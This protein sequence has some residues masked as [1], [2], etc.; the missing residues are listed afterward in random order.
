[1]THPNG[2]A[3]I[4]VLVADDHP[5]MREGLA[6]AI[7]SQ[8]DMCVAGEA[9][10]GAEALA[11]HAEARPD[12]TLMDISLPDMCGVSAMLEIRRAC[13]TARIIMLTT[14]R[15]DAQIRRAVQGGAAGFLLKSSVRSD[16]L[17]AIRAVHAGQ[18]RI[19]AEIALEL[20]QHLNHGSLSEREAQVLQCAA[21]GNSNKRI[22]VVLA[23]SEET[24]KAHMR[25]ILSK[26]DANDRT[27]AVAI[28]IRRGI[29]SL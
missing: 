6:Q 5:M 27:H 14:F 1:M 23:I 19:P 13:P 24:V 28:A 4:R 20:A 10:T 7:A 12:V 11:A 29:I 2:V 21:C 16:L 9:A 18:R 22:A 3:R 26:L 17:E 15:R 8:P 25:T